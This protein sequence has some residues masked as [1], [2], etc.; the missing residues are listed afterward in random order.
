MVSHPEDGTPKVK[1]PSSFIIITIFVI[2]V[3]AG[4]HILYWTFD[5]VFM[6]YLYIIRPFSSLFCCIFL[7]CVTVV[8]FIAAVKHLSKGVEM[9]F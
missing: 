9:S 4:F 8:G 5:C 6:N 3:V 2:A 7:Q 1:Y